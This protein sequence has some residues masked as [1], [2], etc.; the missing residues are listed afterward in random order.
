MLQKSSSFDSVNNSQVIVIWCV[1]AALQQSRN[2]K[3]SERAVKG[4]CFLGRS[5]VR[6]IS[7]ASSRNSLRVFII[8]CTILFGVVDVV[9]FYQVLLLDS[10]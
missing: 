10:T 4:N 6:L 9:I 7:A 3:Q 8:V 2:S 5:T 1:L